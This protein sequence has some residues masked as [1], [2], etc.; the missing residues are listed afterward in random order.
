P[1]S[2]PRP[3]GGRRVSGP[4]ASPTRSIRTPGKMTISQL[5]ARDEASAS[6]LC[7]SVLNG[8]T[9][10][11][12]SPGDRSIRKFARRHARDLL[13]SDLAAVKVNSPLTTCQQ[14][15]RSR[16]HWP[17]S[18]RMPLKPSVDVLA[19]LPRSTADSRDSNLMRATTDLYVQE[20]LH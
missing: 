4:P 12:H 18:P 3:P 14:N 1:S 11:M 16:E 2:L 7:L 8:R 17:P 15:S 20:A 10:P 13:T 9:V 6:R 19:D 5:P